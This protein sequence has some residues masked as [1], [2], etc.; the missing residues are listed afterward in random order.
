MCMS[1]CDNVY[2]MNHYVH[3]PVSTSEKQLPG[4]AYDGKVYK[5]Y[6]HI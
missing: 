5:L 4:N 2:T 3:Q 6:I 1:V